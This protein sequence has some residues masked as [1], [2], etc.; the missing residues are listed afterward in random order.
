MHTGQEEVETQEDAEIGDRIGD[1]TNDGRKVSYLKKPMVSQKKLM[2]Y[3]QKINSRSNGNLQL[4]IDGFVTKPRKVTINK[5]PG[6]PLGMTVVTAPAKTLLPGVLVADLTTGGPAACTGLINRGDHL[7]TINGF[8]T[9]GV[10][11]A[12]VTELIRA[13][14]GV[15][16]V[17]L[18]L[19]SPEGELPRFLSPPKSPPIPRHPPADLFQNA[20]PRLTAMYLN[21]ENHVKFTLKKQLDQPLGIGISLTLP[22]AVVPGVFVSHVDPRGLAGSSQG[23]NSQKLLH[24]DQLM[25]VNGQS[26]TGRTLTEAKAI[27]R[28]CAKTREVRLEVV[29]AHKPVRHVINKVPHGI[30]TSCGVVVSIAKGSEGELANFEPGQRILTI[31]GLAMYPPPE[32]L[33]RYLRTDPPL[34]VWT[35]QPL[36]LAPRSP[37]LPFPRPASPPDAPTPASPLAPVLVMPS[38]IPWGIPI[39]PP[40]PG[41]PIVEGR[42]V[43]LQFSEMSP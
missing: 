27:L 24:G 22:D 17:I 42:P 39:P 41:S 33:D 32:T 12:K 8:S 37:P 20:D 4:D 7:L 2:D 15:R 16:E 23:E 26:M 3:E 25:M 30:V 5:Q 6:V 34:V 38:P 19:L 29:R 13:V 21:P 43:R 11:V 1:L 36:P 18:D 14:T 9:I 31:N 10:P 40:P 35:I 28:E